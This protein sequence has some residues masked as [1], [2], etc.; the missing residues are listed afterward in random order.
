MKQ[1]IAQTPR[2][3][4]LFLY[5]LCFE[6]V[7]VRSDWGCHDYTGLPRSIQLLLYEQHWTIAMSAAAQDV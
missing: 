2:L 6:M 4:S 1:T 7:M 5:F 3:Q